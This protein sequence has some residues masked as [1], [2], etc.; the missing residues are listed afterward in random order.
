MV[1]DDV[2]DVCQ[3]WG[4][5]ALNKPGVGRGGAGGAG[6]YLERNRVPGRECK[7]S[8]GAISYEIQKDLSL[9]QQTLPELLCAVGLLESTVGP[10]G[11]EG[12]GA[13]AQED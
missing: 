7:Y 13:L 4:C 5:R 10:V 2:T 8:R 12:N 3:A 11:G 9:I 6:L 1:E